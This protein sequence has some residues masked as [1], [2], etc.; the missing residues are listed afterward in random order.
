MTNAGIVLA[1]TPIGNARDAS[2]RLVEL[3]ATADVIAAE[4]TRRLRD[5]ARRLDVTLSARVLSHHDH[6][7]RERAHALVAEA[8]A[9]KL[10][11]V[12]T[13]AGMP[14]IS[15]PGFPLVQAAAA[16]GVPVTVAPG[17]SAV[18]TALAVSGLATD[19]FAFEGFVPRKAAERRRAFAAA[20]GDARTLVYFESPHRIAQCLSDMRDEF[21]DERPV[22]VCRE[23]TK[24][25][26]EVIRGTLAE[27][28]GAFDNPRGEYV[29]VVGGAPPQASADP[30]SLVT[31][32]LTLADGGMRLKEAVAKVATEHSSSKRELYDAVISARAAGSRP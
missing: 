16:A 30:Q 20:A 1:A 8:A 6:N 18:L 2:A 13:D 7:E 19:R 27:V 21:G 29:V 31:Q 26:E 14:T 24:T 12:V 15:D 3:L 32:V 4:D 23:L 10:V 5:L 22:A 28:A 17:P 25:H 11:L 9:G